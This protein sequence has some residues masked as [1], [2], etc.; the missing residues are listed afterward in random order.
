MLI[1]EANKFNSPKNV[2]KAIG[3]V[4]SGGSRE[5]T[6]GGLKDEAPKALR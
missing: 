6:A 4:T 3:N 2:T 1:T 5:V